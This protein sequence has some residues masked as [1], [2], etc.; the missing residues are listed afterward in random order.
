M[1]VSN[2]LIVVCRSS[3][4][5]SHVFFKES[6]DT[7]V[8]NE[9]FI[10][11]LNL[12]GDTPAFNWIGRILILRFTSPRFSYFCSDFLSNLLVGVILNSNIFQEKY[13]SRQNAG[14]RRQNRHRLLSDPDRQGVE[15]ESVRAGGHFT[16]QG[17]GGLCQVSYHTVS[18]I[19]DLTGWLNR[20]LVW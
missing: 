10:Y 19:S 3:V 13:R 1:S 15:D 8:T 5:Y 11:I 14:K 12:E 18:C 4:S 17:P 2:C 9:A 6:K 20:I 16:H 7:K